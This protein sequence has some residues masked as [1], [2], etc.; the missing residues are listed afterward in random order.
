MSHPVP[1]SFFARL[2]MAW[3]CFFRIL[4]RPSFA[5]LILPAYRAE[6]P[7]G[8]PAAP[9]A[10]EV[11]A[12]QAHAAG[13]FMLS[14]LQ[15]EGR[16]ID[17]VQEDVA[18]FSDAEVG[19]AARGV[20][21]GCRKV[22]GQYLTLQPVRTE[23]EGVKITIPPGF[24]AQRIRLTGNVVGQPPFEGTLRHPGWVAAKVS[25][26]EIPKALDPTVLAPAEVELG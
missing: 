7:A 15:R 22:V 5:Q 9:T 26:P 11:P 3:V 2:A 14:M 24:D 1:P 16:F 4:F 8:E 12:A 25:L 6:L 18:A 20:Q 17:F 10:P 19:A 13:L 23:Q 21:Q